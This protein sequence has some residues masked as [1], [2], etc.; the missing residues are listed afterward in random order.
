MRGGLR[1]RHRLTRGLVPTSSCCLF[2]SDDLGTR[3]VHFFNR[4]SAVGWVDVD[5]A[6]GV[7]RAFNCK[8]LP[9]SVQHG[10]LKRNSPVA[11]PPTQ[12]SSTS[13]SRK[14]WARFVPS[15]PE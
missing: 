3:V 12:T 10:V 14:F 6:H 5:R 4:L 13:W 8:V 2:V 7:A 11:S 1:A 15:N 9:Q